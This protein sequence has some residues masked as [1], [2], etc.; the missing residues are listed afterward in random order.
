MFAAESFGGNQGNLN[1]GSQ[2]GTQL[3]AAVATAVYTG[4]VSYILLMG[5][6]K[7]IGLRVTAQ[8]ENQG[9]DL[10]L[11]EETGYRY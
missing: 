4:L 9:L 3:C 6:D 7:V 1:I 5:I 8:D 10:A 11:H 2:F